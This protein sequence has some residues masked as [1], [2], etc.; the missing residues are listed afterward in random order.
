MTT[1]RDMKLRVRSWPCSLDFF[2]LNKCGMVQILK[3][4]L[5]QNLFTL[6]CARFGTALNEI[7]FYTWPEHRNRISCEPRTKGSFQYINVKNTM[8]LTRW[9]KHTS[10][11]LK[12][13]L[14]FVLLNCSITSYAGAQT[15]HKRQPLTNVFI[16]YE[17]KHQQY[18][19]QIIK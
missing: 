6:I 1:D 17:L 8:S 14:F 19:W 18:N 10:Q 11:H 12:L 13:S 16:H 15:D 5:V 4:R 3:T 2:A 7:M 9:A